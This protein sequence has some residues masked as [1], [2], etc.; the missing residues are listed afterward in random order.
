M[1]TLMQPSLSAPI[2]YVVS[3]FAVVSW[4]D[5]QCHIASPAAVRSI[6]LKN[7]EILGLL[8]Q[9]ASPTSLD[10]IQTTL[11]ATQLA[12]IVADL[13]RNEIL[14]IADR[15]NNAGESDILRHWTPHE[16]LF[17]VR[18]RLGK[19]GTYRFR[20]AIPEEA[21]HLPS[22]TENPIFLPDA[23][24]ISLDLTTALNQRHSARD[25]TGPPLTLSQLGSLLDLSAR[26]RS[27]I[28]QGEPSHRSYPSG[29][30]KYPL[31]I[32]PVI[33]ENGAVGLPPGVYRYLSNEHALEML[34]PFNEEARELRDR[35]RR[36]ADLSGDNWIHFSISAR[37]ARTA[38]KY[39]DFAYALILKELGGLFQNLYLAASAVGLGA[40]AL[41]NG[42][43][44]TLAKLSRTDW[45][46]EP[47]VG[48][49]A[50]GSVG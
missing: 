6:R 9:F 30:A 15:E 24:E 38:W 19:G 44:Q 41:G 32:Y 2:R 50:I 22:R 36:A 45:L 49:F 17:H 21:P 31:E 46:T 11:P 42:P 47:P 10:E 16:L 29:G 34:S 35:A 28:P 43:F 23:K 14:W 12:E 8:H 5:G 26:V 39:E 37:F 20:D 25:F 13:Q 40:C 4:L 27:G 1:M 18:S 7:P 33:P 3:R 48:E